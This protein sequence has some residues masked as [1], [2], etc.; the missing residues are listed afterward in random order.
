M[1]QTTP[2]QNSKEES[3]PIEK[4]SLSHANI[5]VRSTLPDG[6]YTFDDL[7]RA[8]FDAFQQFTPEATPLTKYRGLA[9]GSNLSPLL[10]ILALDDFSRSLPDSTH[11][12]D[13][14][15]VY[16]RYSG[17]K[18]ETDLD[19]GIVIAKGDKSKM[20]KKDGV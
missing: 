20:L 2:R 5:M 3:S 7:L 6:S 17:T 9:Q 18:V 1:K 14:F 11:Y 4:V 8:Q 10:T 12:S 19:K 13:D 16:S 15:L